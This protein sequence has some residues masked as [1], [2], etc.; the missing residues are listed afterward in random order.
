MIQ[1]PFENHSAQHVRKTSACLLFFHRSM[2]TLYYIMDI[3]KNNIK[4][5]QKLY[6][7]K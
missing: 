3:N 4:S 7:K 6:F 5:C 1:A 2:S